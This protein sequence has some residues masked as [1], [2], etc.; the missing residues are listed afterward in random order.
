MSPASYIDFRSANLFR[1][2]ISHSHLP[3]TNSRFVSVDCF[4]R[5]DDPIRPIA[6]DDNLIG[7]DNKTVAG[8]QG[9][10]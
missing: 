10:C 3:I 9:G 2:Y 4:V 8:V 1:F 7:N 5:R 6:H